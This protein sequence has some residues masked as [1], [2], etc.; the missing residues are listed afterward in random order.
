VTELAGE[1][2][3]AFS[4]SNRERLFNGSKLFLRKEGWVGSETGVKLP[5][6]QKA[7]YVLY[8]RTEAVSPYVMI[9]P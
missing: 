9:I 4:G 5:F 3:I 6:F 2:S 7:A 8:S 1:D